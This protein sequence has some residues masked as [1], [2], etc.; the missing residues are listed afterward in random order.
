MPV[1]D[2]P[3]VDVE[4]VTVRLDVTQGC[5]ANPYTPP[6]DI[7]VVR[8]IA[9]TEPRKVC[10]E[11]S[12][13]QLLTVPSVIGL[14]QAEAASLLRASGFNVAVE[15]VRSD[16]PAGTVTAQDPAAGERALQTSTVTITVSEG[17]RLVPVPAVIGR[18]EGAARAELQRAGF[19]VVTIVEAA[20]DPDAPDCDHRPGV[21][22]WQS[23]A[24]GEAARPG[25]TVTIRVNP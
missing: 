24:G 16:Q 13:Y 7:R 3:T 20:C 17:P 21:V 8:Y 6:G 10:E 23:P 1:R 14:P 15:T 19:Q 5:L 25:S 2:F 9:G 18:P 4:Y 12:E 11:P 22:W